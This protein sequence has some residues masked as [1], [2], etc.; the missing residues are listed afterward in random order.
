MKEFTGGTRLNSAYAGDSFTPKSD[1]EVVAGF[2]E[3]WRK[4]P[5]G[6]SGVSI[7]RAPRAIP[8]VRAI[9]R[10]FLTPQRAPLATTA[11]DRYPL[12]GD[13]LGLRS[14]VPSIGADQRRSR[15]AQLAATAHESVAVASRRAAAWLFEWSR[16]FRRREV[17]ALQSPAASSAVR[18][19]V[20]VRGLKAAQCASCVAQR[21]MNT[22]WDDQL[23]SSIK[24]S[25]AND[26][27]TV[28]LWGRAAE[29]ASAG[30]IWFDCYLYGNDVGAYSSY[31]GE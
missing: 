10:T 17:T 5:A 8:A 18:S 15:L 4:P 23:L 13:E 11:G 31:R 1:S 12:S 28:N 6:R 20:T 21:S 22:S 25:T 30:Q 3:D 7:I 2:S 9:D 19:T 26:A 27:F 16:G 29:F 24:L 14:R